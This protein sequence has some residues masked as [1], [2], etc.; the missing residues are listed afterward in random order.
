MIKITQTEL[1]A[2]LKA[3]N[4]KTFGVIFKKRTDGQ[5]R[6]MCARLGVTKDVK[7][8]GLNYDPEKRGLLPVYDMNNGRRM[9]NLRGLIQATIDGEVYVVK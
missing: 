9:V 4:G 8:V 7:G 2:K 1:T 5:L 3:T 6:N